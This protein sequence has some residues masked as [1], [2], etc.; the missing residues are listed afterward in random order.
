MQ[1]IFKR[2]VVG[3]ISTAFRMVS[4]VNKQN[5]N[6]IHFNEISQLILDGANLYDDNIK[7]LL[8]EIFMS[9]F[10][11]MTKEMFEEKYQSMMFSKYL[12]NAIETEKHKISIISTMTPEEVYKHFAS[13][14]TITSA[15]EK[16][17]LDLEK[18]IFPARKLADVVNGLANGSVIQ[19]VI[20]KDSAFNEIRDMLL[21]GTPFYSDEIKDKLREVY[22]SNY[23]DITEEKFEEKYRNYLVNYKLVEAIELEKYK[24]GLIGNL[25]YQKLYETVSSNI[26]IE[27]EKKEI[28]D[29]LARGEIPV[30]MARPIN[31]AFRSGIFADI[32][33]QIL[34]GANLYDDN[35]REQMLKILQEN[36]FASADKTPEEKYIQLLKKEKLVRVI[37]IEKYKKSKLDVITDQQLYEIVKSGL[38]ISE[39]K[40]ALE[41][42]LANGNTPKVMKHNICHTL[43]VVIK[44]KKIKTKDSE[45]NAIA[46][47]I[48]SGSNLYD[49]DIKQD[50]IRILQSVLPMTEKEALDRYR[51]K[52]ANPVVIKNI[53]LERLKVSMNVASKNSVGRK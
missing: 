2:T 52:L 23:P 40:A 37:E 11:E 46:D 16:I 15:K 4:S 12:I 6:A 28:D 8:Q 14:E 9:N 32:T 39:E 19:K 49:E 24:T 33:D 53:E 5:V 51:T 41:S 21:S 17:R 22:K 18:G 36:D 47:R 43:S 7:I 3:N 10:P 50:Y 44:S 30:L 29:M 31:Q 45:F 13:V 25:S 48:L 38:D 27:E 26:D 20:I 1:G 34:D 42:E 35:I